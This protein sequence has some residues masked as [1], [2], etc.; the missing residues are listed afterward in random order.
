MR[1]AL[2]TNFIGP[3]R[4]PL[5]EEI[6]R[7]AGELRVLVSTRM[8]SNR[9]WQPD[10]GELD[11]VVQRNL[12]FHRL[13]KTASFQEA[14]ELHI[15]YDTAFQLRRYRPDVIITGELGARSLQAVAYAR[16]TGTPVVL[17][18]TLSDRIEQA[19]GRLRTLFRRALVNNV[20]AI[21]VNGAD[22]ARYMH[23]FGIPDDRMLHVPCTT[24]IEELLHAPLDKPHTHDLLYVGS[25]SERKGVELLL[26][27]IDQWAAVNPG[28]NLSLTIVGDGPERAR[29]AGRE[30]PSHV[31]ITWVGSVPYH[32]LPR[33]FTA[34]SILVFPTL[35]DEWGL[36]VN[37][38]LAAGLPVA[39]SI[40]GQAVEELIEDGVNGWTFEPRDAASVAALLDR[41]MNA[42]ASTLH[43]MRGAARASVRH[44]TAHNQAAR[45]V[46][47]LRSV[48]A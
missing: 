37:E 10:W 36:V 24:G 16:L 3:Y 45:I 30:L 41:V 4:V 26:D 5:F 22:G 46:E 6:A 31:Q 19:R 18:A 27:G 25:I 47:L 34:G 35:G 33:Y 29:L 1:V 2:L 7:E 12:M 43:A 23:R 9:D 15:P 17:W 20:N 32:D 13:W 39:G 48:A 28:R 40:Y 42:D 21:I 11:V 38:A 14:Y 8:E 44:I